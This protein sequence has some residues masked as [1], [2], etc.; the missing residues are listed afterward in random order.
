[1]TS[2]EIKQSFTDN[3]GKIIIS[4]GVDGNVYEWEGGEVCAVTAEMVMIFLGWYIADELPWKIELL[5]V[6]YQMGVLFVGRV[7]GPEA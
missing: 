7:D 4:P 1:M 3:P 6:D 5:G 2:E